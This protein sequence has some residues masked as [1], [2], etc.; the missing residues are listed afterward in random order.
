M[1]KT[2]LANRLH[3]AI[4]G[5][6]N[7]GKSSLINALTNQDLALVSSVAGTTTDP[8]YKAMELLPL[9]P[10]V[11]IDTAGIDDVGEL[12]ALRIKKTIQVLN[13][14]DL[15]IVVLD[16]EA[17]IGNYELDLINKIKDRNIPFI[18][19]VNKIDEYPKLDTTEWEK[20][21]SCKIHAVSAVTREGINELKM[22]LVKAAPQEKEIPIIGDLVNPGDVVILV[23]PIDSAAP[24]GRLILPQVQTLRDL[25]D[26]GALGLVTREF[27]LTEALE[28]LE[29]KPRM[30]VTDSQAF[31]YVSQR[32]PKEIPL[33]GFSVLF[34]RHK[35]DLEIYTRGAKALR[36]LKPGDKVLVA[37]ACTH[38]RQP[39]DIGTVKLPNWL[40]KHV[41]GELNFAHVAGRDFPTNISEYKL[42]IQCGGCMASRR[43]ILYR[44]HSA[45]NKAIPIVNYGILIAYLHGIL[46]RALQPF[47]DALAI[48]N[49]EY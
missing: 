13:K 21:L 26:H 49:E 47:P 33:T 3:I 41:G 15:A 8:V 40:Q 32:V 23:T 42:I 10:I 6:R 25:L 45:D 5:R 17:G 31:E 4:F 34:A 35:G 27:E 28:S 22:V 39:E 29:Q 9:G 24:K 2:P 14:T 36:E 46:D 48:W 11:M 1:E 19:A 38:H 7:A 43:E 12:G 20:Q 44:L 30:V 18:T 37:E 16:P